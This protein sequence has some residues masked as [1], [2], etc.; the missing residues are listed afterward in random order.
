ME[1]KSTHSP[2]TLITLALVTALIVITIARFA[3]GQTSSACSGA[4]ISSFGSC[5]GF[6]TSGSNLSRPSSDCCN[7][8]RDLMSNGQD[9]VC[10][11]VTGGVPFKV[12]FNRDLAISLPR[13]CRTSGVPIE[14]KATARP[15]P[16][17]GT[18]NQGGPITNPG[19]SPPSSTAPFT[20]LPFTPPS[21][22]IPGGE[23][24]V[25][26][27]TPPGMRPTLTPSAA[28]ESSHRTSTFRSLL[29]A[30]V[31]VI[32]LIKLN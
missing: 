7:S 16:T 27:L 23:E 20:P 32:M 15:V 17:P 2:H 4:M 30:L 21:S 25:P 24:L 6:L 22:S 31:G 14:C 3:D 18:P 10:L 8:L 19:L 29:V 12:P 9:C 11:I 28:H 1:K 13:A 5:I 26:T